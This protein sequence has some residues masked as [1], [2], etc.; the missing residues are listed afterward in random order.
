[1][2]DESYYRAAGSQI[3]KRTIEKR[4]RRSS[5]RIKRRRRV[6][7]GGEE[8]RVWKRDVPLMLRWNCNQ[9][10]CY[11]SRRRLP[12]VSRCLQVSDITHLSSELRNLAKNGSVHL[13]VLDR[14]WLMPVP[15]MLLHNQQ[16]HLRHDHRCYHSRPMSHAV[17]PFTNIKTGQDKN[18]HLKCIVME[19]Y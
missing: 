6:G 14:N 13:R 3:G 8:G 15:T 5:R 19:E 4:T 7:G 16:H 11:N 17:S 1:M 9:S 12:T 18:W 2:V 10:S